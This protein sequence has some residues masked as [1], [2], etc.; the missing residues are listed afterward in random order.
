[1]RV[2]L[3]NDSFPPL[4]D[5]VAN[6]VVNYA[7]VINK[8][9]GEAIV[10]TPR[11]PDADDSKFP[12]RVVRY[13]SLNT[14]KLVGYR[15]GVPF[16]RDAMHIL[17]E[18]KPDIIHTHCPIMSLFMAREVREV[19]KSPLICTYHTKFD[20]DFDR[21][22]RSR[23]ISKQC[24]KALVANI[25]A[26]DDVWAVNEGTGENLMSLGYTK[27][28]RVMKNGVD[29][30]RTPVD[31]TKLNALDEQYGLPAGVPVFLF[32]GRVM[33]YKG[34]RYILEG[35]KGLFDTGR[36]FRM[37]FVGDGDNRKEVEQYASDLG[38]REK[39]I[40]TGVLHDRDAL[41]V[42][43]T[44][45][46]VFLLPSVYDNNPLVVKEAAACGTPS[47]LIRDSSSSD[48]VTD[49]YNGVLIKE[50]S[51]DMTRALIGFCDDPSMAPRLGKA[52][53]ETLYKSW[54]DCVDQAMV[55]YQEI[56]DMKARGELDSRPKAR[57]DGLINFA[58]D[59]YRALERVRDIGRE[60]VE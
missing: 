9:Y 38:V 5:G 20:Y 43:Y 40:F 58:A 25:D 11:Y 30:D 53:S 27:E 55:R 41:K 28:Y 4:I 51:D 44:R 35:I 16:G 13:T 31:E 50:D 8:K 48:G 49:G 32:V 36:D 19:T 60:R 45:A 15:A 24:I 29:I 37:V 17:T 52:A 14:A 2:L 56:L 39:C 22:L 54:E 12:F 18:F 3:L 26:C 6:T 7:T 21:A 33:W 23:F 42:W 1:M 46:D 47:V 34:L 57:F 59:M 10:A